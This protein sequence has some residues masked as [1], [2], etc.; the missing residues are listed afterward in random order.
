MKMLKGIYIKKMGYSL[1]S[2]MG[3]VS[4]TNLGCFHHF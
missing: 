3:K 2:K 1:S 4:F